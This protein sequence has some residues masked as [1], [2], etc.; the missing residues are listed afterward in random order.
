M[1]NPKAVAAVTLTMQAILGNVA[2]I[3]PDLGDATVT[4]LPLDKARSSNTNNQLN[5][6]LYQIA[7][8]AAWRNMNV[9]TQVGPLETGNPPLPLSLHYLLTAFGRDNDS[10][11]P[12]GHHLLGQAMSILYDHA[13]LGPDEIRTAT[14]SLGNS[15]LDR[16]VERVRIT[17]HPY[18]LEEISKLWTGFATNYRLSVAYEVSVV[19]IDS[20]QSRRAPLPVLMRGPGD[21]G[22]LSQASLTSPFPSLEQV[23]LP[24][25]QPSALLGDT[26]TLSG[27]NLDGTNLGVQFNHPSFPAPVEVAPLPGGAATQIQVSIPNQPASWPAGLYSVAVLV[28][29]PGESYRRTTN[30]LSFALAPKITNMVPPS[31]G[32]SSITVS[33][34]PEVQ[35]LQEA[36]LLVGDQELAATAVAANAGTLAFNAQNL[37][38]G[39]YFVRLRV[40]G[41][42]SLLVNRKVNPPVFDTTQRVTIP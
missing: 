27:D 21:R 42:D 32:D 7:P 30:L 9:P 40:D 5:L 36:T 23:R 13:L 15:N 8:D 34:V 18:S 19:L 11:L 25:S 14:A 35:P 37:A 22:V 12:N 10:S 20:T 3:D 4:V 2:L 17:L 41:V 24:N 29:R 28:Q 1:S 33:C 16:Q 6:F 38:G 39:Q 26:L 31:A